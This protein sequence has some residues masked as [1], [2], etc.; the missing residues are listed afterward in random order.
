MAGMQV[1]KVER[2]HLSPVGSPLSS[3][4][5]VIEKRIVEGGTETAAEP[6]AAPPRPASARGSDA[7]A[8]AFLPRSLDCAA[9]VVTASLC[10]TMKFTCVQVQGQGRMAA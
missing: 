6:Q 5:S 3:P 1:A 9:P 2:G 10:D 8:A 4:R 7:G